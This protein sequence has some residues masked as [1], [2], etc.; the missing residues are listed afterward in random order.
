MPH[1]G[2]D[3]LIQKI[4][5]VA[6]VVSLHAVVNKI[7][8]MCGR[9]VQNKRLSLAAQNSPMQPTPVSQSIGE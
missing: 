9:C 4:R 6:F 5:E 7:I 1:M 2:G 8:S 3:K